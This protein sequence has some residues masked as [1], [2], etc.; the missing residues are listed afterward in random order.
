MSG[1]CIESS[2]SSRMT[3]LL[4]FPFLALLVGCAETKVRSED[5]EVVEAPYG[6]V[7]YCRQN[8]DREECSE[9]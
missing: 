2:G 1:S 4:F 5:G 3:W 7:V 6:F 9:P 8:P